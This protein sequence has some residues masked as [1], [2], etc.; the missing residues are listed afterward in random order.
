MGLFF[1]VRSC[2]VAS[3][4]TVDRLDDGQI[5]PLKVRVFVVQRVT[6]HSMMMLLLSLRC[7]WQSL[8]LIISRKHGQHY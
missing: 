4:T 6:L 8:K 5:W 2:A 7:R 1:L 3:R